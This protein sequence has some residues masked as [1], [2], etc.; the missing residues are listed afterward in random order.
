VKNSVGAKSPLT[1]GYG[2]A[3]AGGYF[4]AELKHSGYDAIIFEG[5][6]ESPVYLWIKD[7]KLLA[8]AIMNLENISLDEFI[9][10]I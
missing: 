8:D 3:E 6:A 2:D 9:R 1:G 10:L 4:G 7:A 5:R